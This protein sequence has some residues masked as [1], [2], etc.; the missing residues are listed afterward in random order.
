MPDFSN[1]YLNGKDAADVTNC[2]ANLYTIQ[3][4]AQCKAWLPPMEGRG[5]SRR[6]N[7]NQTMLLMLH[8]DLTRSSL[9]IPAAGKLVNRIA[10]QLFFNP[11]AEE[12][13]IEFRRNGAS[14]F[15]AGARGHAADEPNDAAYMAGPARFRVTFDLANY[16]E[17]VNTAFALYGRPVGGDDHAE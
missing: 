6:Y 11:D 5:K 9:S 7:R 4:D 1:D 10:E 2:G 3:D 13:V 14:F 17:A 16:R 12:L 15:Y 8:S